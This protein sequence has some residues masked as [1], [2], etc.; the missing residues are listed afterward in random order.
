MQQ[1]RFGVQKHNYDENGLPLFGALSGDPRSMFDLCEKGLDANKTFRGS[2][3]DAQCFLILAIGKPRVHFL[4]WTFKVKKERLLSE[5]RLSG[6]GW[7]LNPPVR[8]TGADW[9]EF[10]RATKN[11]IGFGQID[12]LPYAETLAQLAQE[13]FRPGVFDAKT[14]GFLTKIADYGHDDFQFDQFAAAIVK[15]AADSQHGP[16]ESADASEAT[17][18]LTQKL[19]ELGWSGSWLRPYL[20]AIRSYETKLRPADANLLPNS[21]SAVTEEHVDELRSRLAEMIVRERQ[22]DFRR[23]LLEAYGGRCAISGTRCEA[24]L[25]AA[26]IRPYSGPT[27]STIKNGVLLRSDL[28]RLFDRHLIAIDPE[29]F[30]ISLSTVLKKSDY[31]QFEN[32]KL[33]LPKEREMRPATEGL[34]ERWQLFTSIENSEERTHA[35]LTADQPE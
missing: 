5:G 25:E 1:Y 20:K 9:D 8:L 18:E 21:E 31:R 35:S 6:P 10:Q 22:D 7:M 12:G 4:W 24:A 15:L 29:T 33:R 27:S 19:R 11:N 26:H 3:H 34:R 14:I 17:K 30:R 13:R 2:W 32:L 16:E 28:H 23:V